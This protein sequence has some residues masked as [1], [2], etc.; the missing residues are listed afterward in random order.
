[1]EKGRPNIRKIQSDDPTVA[2]TQGASSTPIPIQRN[3]IAHS[4]RMLGV[5]INP[6]GDLTDH[7]QRLKQKADDFSRLPM[8]PRLTET[9]VQIF[10]Q[11]IYIPSMRYSLAAVA[12][13][14]E[15]LAYQS[16]KYSH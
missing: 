5:H 11:S 1:M 3:T 14:E 4:T 13:N 8:S 10:H 6:M 7:L 15:S 12:A 16:N 2:L 9:D